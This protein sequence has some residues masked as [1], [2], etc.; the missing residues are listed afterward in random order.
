MHLFRAKHI[1]NLVDRARKE[2]AEGKTDVAWTL[3]EEAHI[4]SQPLAAHHMYVHW[5]MLQLAWL[6]RDYK[7]VFGQFLRFLVAAPGS[8]SK[9]YPMGNTG[10]SNV[11]MFTPMV[12]SP[13]IEAKLKDLD[14]QEKLR[15]E[16]GGSIKE[17]Q[18]TYPLTRK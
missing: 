11:D 12:I 13:R 4:V 10:R 15:L 16:N 14:H 1:D 9:R 2:I 8:I 5:E 3:L 17:S 18:R 6:T 7:E